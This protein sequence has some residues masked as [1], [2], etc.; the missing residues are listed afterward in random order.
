[1]NRLIWGFVET[2]WLI[3]LLSGCQAIETSADINPVESGGKAYGAF[4]SALQR[5]FKEH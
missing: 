1:M 5:V 3:N 4:S 2:R